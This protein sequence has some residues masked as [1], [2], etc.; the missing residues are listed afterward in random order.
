MI[1]SR[2]ISTEIRQA[3]TDSAPL[4]ATSS[5]MLLAFAASCAGIFLDQRIVTGVSAWLKPAKFAISTAIFSA[6]VAWLFRYIKVWPRFVGATGWVLATVLVL[7]VGIID[8]Q[9][10]RGVS[11]HFNLATPLD[12]ALF[13]VMG[14]AIAILWLASVGVLAALFRQKFANPA[15]GWWVRMGMLITVIGSAQRLRRWRR[16]G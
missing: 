1:S 11:S 10:A 5:V 3:W 8:V 16:C 9:A 2:R 7:E 14:V 12:A 13:G 4:T 6:T 15:W